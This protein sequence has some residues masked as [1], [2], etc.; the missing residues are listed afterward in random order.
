M[1][2][3]LAEVL[4][5][6]DRIAVMSHVAPDGDA[7]GT[8]LAMTRALR[9]IG[10]QAC[11]V[12]TDP[13]PV[14]YSGLPGADEIVPP[15]ALPF[16]PELAFSVDAADEGRLGT[17]AELFRSAPMRAVLDHHATDPG[18]GDVFH[19]EGERA[20]CG[21]IA[22]RL[23]RRLGLEPDR[24]IASCLYMAISTDTGNFSYKN[25]DAEALHAAA[26]CVACGAD[27]EKLSR[28]A[29]RER[30]LGATRLL[31]AA[32]DRIGT[33]AGGRIAWTYV[34]QEMLAAAGAILEDASRICNYLSEIR[35]VTI[36]VYFEQRGADA[37]ISWRANGADISGLARSFGGGGHAAAAGATIRGKH[38]SEVTEE[39]LRATEEYLEGAGRNGNEAAA[40]H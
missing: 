10:K 14:M 18:F 11:A 25:T 17:A 38:V 16:V 9:R 33:R 6:S 34:D 24:E 15:D 29:F 32:L 31:G 5:A 2:E 35:G 23:I 40:L 21:E 13:V 8:A 7:I 19:V 20:S 1:F 30:S 37:K 4:L 39:V 26:D 22:L 36:G 3:Q 28:A 12:L 27:A